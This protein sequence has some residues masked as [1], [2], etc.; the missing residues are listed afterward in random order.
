[1]RLKN[2]YFDNVK[3]PE[4]DFESV[5]GE[6]PQSGTG[7]WIRKLRGA[8]TSR[9]PYPS[10]SIAFTNTAKWIERVFQNLHG[11]HAIAS[12]LG[13]SYRVW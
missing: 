3:I 12:H 10:V 5:L 9:V 11:N 2:V 4:Q 1:M 8:E 13:W 6:G 7:P